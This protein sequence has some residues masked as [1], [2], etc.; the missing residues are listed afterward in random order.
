MDPTT[1]LKNK[2]LVLENRR[3]A[4]L[5]LLKA[6]FKHTAESLKPSNIIKGIVREADN[7]PGLMDKLLSAVIGLVTGYLAK[8]VLAGESKNMF[9]KMFGTIVQILVTS[10][11]TK[12]PEFIKSAGRNLVKRVLSKEKIPVNSSGPDEH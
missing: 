6:Q 10:V 11:V 3:A 5:N 8:K 7:S 1:E 4:E 12:N 9:K 2:I